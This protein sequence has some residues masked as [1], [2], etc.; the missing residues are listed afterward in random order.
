[1]KLSFFLSFSLSLSLS[2]GSPLTIYRSLSGPLRRRHRKILK[3]TQKVSEEKK[4]MFE[5]FSRLLGGPVAGGSGRLSFRT[6]F[7]DFFGVSGPDCP[8]DSCKWSGGIQFEKERNNRCTVTPRSDL[9]IFVEIS[10]QFPGMCN[11]K[12]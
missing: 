4:Q 1:M 5:T 6:F 11:E 7:L 8:R 10:P 12:R 3:K 2:L 9:I